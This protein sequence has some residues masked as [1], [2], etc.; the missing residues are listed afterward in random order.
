MSHRA[1]EV[2]RA[3]DLILCEDTR[4]SRTLLA[5]YDITTPVEALHE[6]NEATVVPRLV[7][8]LADGA[9]VALVSDAGTPTLS[10]PGS[11]L[12]ASAIAHDLTVVP[13]PGASAVL[14]ALSASG[15]GGGPF[16]FLGFLDRK[17]EG[18]RRQ[19]GA[20]SR[21]EHPGVLYEA[22]QRVGATLDDLASAGCGNRQAVVARELTKQFE[23]FRRGTV[24]ELA[25]YYREVPPRGEVVIIVDGRGPEVPDPAELRHMVVALRAEGL[26]ARDVARAL[27][28][29][30]GLAR[31][32]A[33]RLAHEDA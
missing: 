8:R 1:V 4:H 16:T 19:V 32:E 7:R 28:E 24:A 3:V 33:Y 22:P 25:E 15:L 10:D 30:A 17:G 5:H 6:H 13:V 31:N 11:R 2:L 20:L 12:V 18:R 9:S 23:E 27:V 29:R 26:G 14:A 21:L